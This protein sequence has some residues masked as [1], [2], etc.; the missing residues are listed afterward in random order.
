MTLRRHH[1]TGIVASAKTGTMAHEWDVSW[2]TM[3]P[4]G[5]G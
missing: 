5:N 2:W 1:S 4:V 3:V